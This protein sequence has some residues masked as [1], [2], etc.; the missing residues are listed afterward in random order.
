MTTKEQ[1]KALWKL[2]FNDSPEFTDLYFEQRYKDEINRAAMCDGRIVSALQ[3][4]PYPMTFCGKVIETAYISGACTH[5]DY[6][7][8]GVMRG[9]LRDTHR[10]LYGKGVLLSALIPAERWLFDYYARSGYAASFGYLRQKTKVGELR[11]SSFYALADE[12]GREDCLFDH[13]HYLATALRKRPCCVQHYRDDFLVIIE[14]LRL[15]KGK[16]LVARKAGQITGMAFCLKE[17]GTLVIK[18]LLADN[19]T[20][21]DSL[22]YEAARIYGADEMDRLLPS[23]SETLCLGMA[24]VIRAEKLLELFAASHPDLELHIHLTGDDAIPENNG[25][26]TLRNGHC[27]R[28]HLTGQDYRDCTVQ[29]FTRLLFQAEHPYMSL[30][31]D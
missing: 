17:N 31:L 21:R 1:V 4:I 10:W 3:A 22:L 7:S 26:Y 28:E 27:L 23:V 13:Y 15:A 12:T 16:L 9:L 19:P 6:R 29:D 20:V 25:H 8:R 2:C 18:E 11:P 14:D 30:M 5:P 24:R